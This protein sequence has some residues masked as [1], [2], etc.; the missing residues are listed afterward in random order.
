M[1]A[2]AAVLALARPINL[3]HG[4]AGAVTAAV[5]KSAVLTVLMQPGPLAWFTGASALLERRC[6]PVVAFL[7]RLGPGHGRTSQLGP[8]DGSGFQAG[9][10]SPLLWCC[11]ASAM[12]ALGPGFFL[13]A[14]WRGSFPRGNYLAKELPP[15]FLLRR[16]W[17]RGE[18]R[19]RV[20][21]QPPSGDFF[22]L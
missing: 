4:H 3:G 11:I 1:A 8:L 7:Q 15:P 16:C 12:H 20:P 17:A 13:L 21:S 14:P 19:G 10:L 5:K 18:G 22:L 6:A 2:A 9:R